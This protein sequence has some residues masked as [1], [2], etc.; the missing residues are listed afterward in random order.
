MREDDPKPDALA[1]D[2]MQR[3][4]LAGLREDAVE[5]GAIVRENRRPLPTLPL[6]ATER[7][8]A[9]MDLLLRARDRE[10]WLLTVICD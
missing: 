8:L 3:A 6:D 9:L 7:E 10:R 2:L 4:T 1:L 5:L